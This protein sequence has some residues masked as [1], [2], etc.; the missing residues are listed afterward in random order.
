MKKNWWQILLL[1]IITTLLIRQ[2]H[3]MDDTPLPIKLLPLSSFTKAY[4]APGVRIFISIWFIVL[5]SAMSVVFI[6]AEKWMHGSKIAKGLT[7]SLAWG[8]IYLLGVVEWYPVFGK[9]SLVADIRI[10]MVD[11]LGILVLGVLSGQ[12][13]ASDGTRGKADVKNTS[14]ILLLVT[15]FYAVGRYIAYSLLKIQSGYI[16]RPLETLIW[17]LVSGISFGALYVLTGRNR[18]EKSLVRKI[19]L[20]GLTN[21]APIW[22]IFNVFYPTIF[23]GSYW[24]FLL[25]RAIVDT[26]FVLAGAYCSERLIGR[27]AYAR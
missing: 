21:V 20:F 18:G 22:I 17:T 12:F 24:D 15:S 9:T 23:E 16:E 10:G 19:A 8:L 1:A 2:G 27:P 26:L 5:F 13:F 14:L 25:G 11:V 3:L 7:F 6:F 4:G